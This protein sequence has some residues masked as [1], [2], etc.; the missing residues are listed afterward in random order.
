MR[1]SLGE[2]PQ[3]PTLYTTYKQKSCSQSNMMSKF[4]MSLCAISGVL[5]NNAIPEHYFTDNNGDLAADAGS[6]YA[7]TSANLP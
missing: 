4:I 2:N 7:L 5:A 6:P 1:V 3:D